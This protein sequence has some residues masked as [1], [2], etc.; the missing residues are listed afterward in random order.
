MQTLAQS[1][2]TGITPRNCDGQ[3]GQCTSSVAA[4]GESWYRGRMN[5]S[6]TEEQRG[7]ALSSATRGKSI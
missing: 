4:N 2:R 7:M 5:A 1:E 6:A 3:L